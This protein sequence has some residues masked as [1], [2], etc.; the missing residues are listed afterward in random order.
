MGYVPDIWYLEKFGKI[1]GISDGAN[2][3]ILE[4]PKFLDKLF[5]N[6]AF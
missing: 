4:N 3:E 6:S 1:S 2:L 5:R